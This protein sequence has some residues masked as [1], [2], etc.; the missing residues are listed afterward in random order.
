[1]ADNS[2]AKEKALVEPRHVTERLN[3]DDQ[4]P[5]EGLTV[6]VVADEYGWHGVGK[7]PG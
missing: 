4:V 3:I 5:G 2:R 7:A 6:A 1:M